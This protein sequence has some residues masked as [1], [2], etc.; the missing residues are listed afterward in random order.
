ML[1]E[2]ITATFNKPREFGQ[3]LQVFRGCGADFEE[4]IFNQAVTDFFEAHSKTLAKTLDD[5]GAL[6]SFASLLAARCS[7]YHYQTDDDCLKQK[8]KESCLLAMSKHAKR[9]YDHQE[10]FAGLGMKNHGQFLNTVVTPVLKE[11]AP[12]LA[13]NAYDE[14]FGGLARQSFQPGKQSVFLPPSFTVQQ[15][16][17]LSERT[18]SQTE[19]ALSIAS[20][21]GDVGMSNVISVANVVEVAQIA[22]ARLEFMMEGKGQSPGIA[23]VAR[24]FKVVLEKTKLVERHHTSW[25][26]CCKATSPASTKSKEVMELLKAD[27]VMNGGHLILL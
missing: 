17:I 2:V 23:N 9:C 16:Q 26:E 11:E 27:Q 8:G 15:L 4:Q 10:T 25:L 12:G 7:H 6:Q 22:A 21:T 18:A 5:F 3:E 24:Q 1:S 13:K 14:Y 20:A 19:S